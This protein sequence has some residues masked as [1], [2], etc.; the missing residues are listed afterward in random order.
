[1]LRLTSHAVLLRLA[2][3][4]VPPG[5]WEP[6][7]PSSVT[8]PCAEAKPPLSCVKCRVEDGGCRKLEHSLRMFEIPGF[9]RV[10]SMRVCINCCGT[11]YT[12]ECLGASIPLECHVALCG[13]EAAPVGCRG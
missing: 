1:M 12:H 4:L 2:F 3:K 8:S 10:Y 7:S 13:G 6:R 9:V 5:A 11:P